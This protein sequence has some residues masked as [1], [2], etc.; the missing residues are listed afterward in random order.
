MENKTDYKEIIDRIKANN[1]LNDEALAAYMGISK[2]TLISW[3]YNSR[4]PSA[5]A[6]RLLDV[7]FLLDMVAPDVRD[8]LLSDYTGKKVIG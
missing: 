3:R 6:L 5:A 8:I 2:N 7:L 1:K 4:K